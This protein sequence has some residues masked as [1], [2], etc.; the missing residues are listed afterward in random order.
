[1]FGPQKAAAHAEIAAREAHLGDRVVDRLQRQ[2]GDP[3]QAVRIGLAVIGQP[4]VVG[5]AHRGGERGI[6]HRA[7][8]QPHARVQKRGVDAVQIHVRDAF[9]RVEAARAPF[10]VGHR[11]GRDGT[12]PCADPADP[13]HALLAAEHLLLDQ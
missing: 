2:H 10:F 6:V 1:L 13:A 8:E 4:P 5:A 9:M 12:L 3:E 7:G 11:L